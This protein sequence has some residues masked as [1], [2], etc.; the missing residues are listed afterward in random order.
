MH[1]AWLSAHVT[2]N[3]AS[4][5]TNAMLYQVPGVWFILLMGIVL[6]Y[7]MVYGIDYNVNGSASLY[8]SIHA[9]SIYVGQ[10]TSSFTNYTALVNHYKLIF[11][12]SEHAR[13][14]QA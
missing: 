5:S 1:V 14:I 9:L 4:H 13:S 12:P 7:Q 6:C 3:H 11:D 8:I 10:C 2:I